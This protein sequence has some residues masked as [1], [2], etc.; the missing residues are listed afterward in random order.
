MSRPPRQNL[1]ELPFHLTARVQNGE[2][3]LTGLEPRI[4]LLIRSTAGVHDARPVAYAIMSNHLHIVAV[5]GRRPLGRYMHML[6]HRVAIMV[7][8]RNRRIG[9]VFQRRYHA[10]ACTD[11]E[12]LRTVL[13]YVH[14]NP[15]RAG[16]C[17]SADQYPWTSHGAYC[18]QPPPAGAGR[19]DLAAEDTVRVF[20]REPN[21]SLPRCRTDYRE[22]LRWRVAF[23]DYLADGGHPG[24]AASP[25]RPWCR[26][27]D[28][29][30]SRAFDERSR[31]A[32]HGVR[33]P[34]P[35]AD[36]GQIAHRVLE[37]A[38]P[39]L[40]L[41]MLRSGSRAHAIRV[42]RQLVI[43]RALD[44]GYSGQQVSRFLRVSPS[45]VSRVAVRLRQ[46]G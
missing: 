10:V 13:A 42:V 8:Q 45:S 14:L 43:A 22:Y 21:G 19:F 11:A 3:L 18:R 15:V 32:V 40:G 5:Q 44:A 31:D 26:G 9:H 36:L 24:S 27:G 17:A 16:I 20:S 23:D 46:P 25:V 6:L 35:R 34:L 2:D 39:D 29:Y 33:V 41:G 12:H 38:A 7:Q 4:V 1:P 30:W 28:A 37:Q